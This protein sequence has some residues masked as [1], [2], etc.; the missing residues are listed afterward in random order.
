MRVEGVRAEGVR[1]E[2]VRVEGVRGEGVR[3]HEVKFL[4]IITF[5]FKEIVFYLIL[6]ENRIMSSFLKCQM[7]TC[8]NKNVLGLVNS[9]RH[10]R[11]C[12][13]P[14]PMLEFLL[15]TLIQEDSN[16]HSILA[17]FPRF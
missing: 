11:H 6:E 16:Q 15:E 7:K 3:G 8:R 2:G 12:S 10:F 13:R 14:N 5:D 9:W 17:V 4:I 1:V